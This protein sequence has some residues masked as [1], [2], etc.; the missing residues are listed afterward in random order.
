MKFQLFDDD[1]L[2][3]VENAL[4]RALTR[5]LTLEE[6][7][8]KDFESLLVRAF[9]RAS[10]VVA[11]EGVFGVAHAAPLSAPSRPTQLTAE[12][13]AAEQLMGLAEPVVQAP[14][15][16]TAVEIAPPPVDWGTAP[17]PTPTPVYVPPAPKITVLPEKKAQRSLNKVIKT[18]PNRP[19][20]YITREEA[21]DLIG[22]KDHKSRDA[23]RV[24]ITQW[25]YNKEVPG[26]IVSNY[27]PPTKGLPGRVFIE[28]ETLQ[29]RNASR[30]AYSV[31][32]RFTA[33]RVNAS[34]RA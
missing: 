28:K 31:S 30:M 4:A 12:Q 33:S 19:N 29:K 21:T 2:R 9:V 22:G 11:R 14:A 13:I 5:A 7:T 17:E 32:N 34:A 8:L 26:V 23:A 16:P 1:D 25:L 20:G 10:R 15:L 6:Q 18:V 24:C 3:G 27:K